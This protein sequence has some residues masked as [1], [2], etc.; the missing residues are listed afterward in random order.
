MR[1]ENDKFDGLIIF[2]KTSSPHSFEWE[3]LH[4]PKMYRIKAYFLFAVFVTVY[5]V[6]IY[7]VMDVFRLY[8]E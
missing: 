2:K 6:L 4:T 3:N 5:L 7:F 8:F 1:E